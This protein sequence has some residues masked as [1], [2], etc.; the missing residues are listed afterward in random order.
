MIFH[1]IFRLKYEKID[2]MI[3]EYIFQNWKIVF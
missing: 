2:E 1:W 3:Y